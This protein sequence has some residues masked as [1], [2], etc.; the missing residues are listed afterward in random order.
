MADPASH[1]AAP[2]RSARGRGDMSEPRTLDVGSLAPGAFGSRSLLW[3]G[4]M[5]IVLIE[6][7]VFALAGCRA[8]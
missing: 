3:W 8:S 5:G 7:T 2:Q 6:G 4:T 1:V